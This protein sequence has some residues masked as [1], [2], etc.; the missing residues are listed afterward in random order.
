MPAMTPEDG[1]R[2]SYVEAV[3]RELE[4]DLDPEGQ[5]SAPAVETGMSWEILDVT[6]SWLACSICG[7]LGY[8]ELEAHGINPDWQAP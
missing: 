8:D 3:T 4:I 5:P 6:D 7:L 2:L 1:H